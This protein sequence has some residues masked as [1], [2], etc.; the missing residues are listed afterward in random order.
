MW[1]LVIAQ[2]SVNE[3]PRY[4][5]FS[6]LRHADYSS[7]GPPEFLSAKGIAPNKTNGGHQ[8]QFLAFAALAWPGAWTLQ[9]SW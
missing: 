6:A 8:T 3:R 9:K 5:I 4:K 2:G 1:A 7:Y